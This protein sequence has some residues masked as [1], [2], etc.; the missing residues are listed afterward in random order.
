MVLPHT[1]PGFKG[2][3]ARFKRE[4][5]A[6]GA[7]SIR[8]PKTGELSPRST[9]VTAPP[10]GVGIGPGV[11]IKQAEKQMGR[12]FT[13]REIESIQRGST[14]IQQVSQQ[15]AQKRQ[16]EEQRKHVA[17]IETQRRVEE[18]M[19]YQQKS[20]IPSEASRWY[21]KGYMDIYGEKGVT[22]VHPSNVPLSPSELKE[23]KEPEGRYE[24]MMYRTKKYLETKEQ[25]AYKKPT[26]L[27]IRT[28]RRGYGTAASLVSSISTK[29]KVGRLA[30]TTGITA[31]A[32][33]ALS[34]VPGGQFIGAGLLAGGGAFYIPKLQRE[35]AESKFMGPVVYR[36]KITEKGSELAAATIGSAIGAKAVT[37]AKTPKIEGTLENVRFQQTKKTGIKIGKTTTGEGE[38]FT[39]VQS[40][41]DKLLGRGRIIKSRVKV[42]GVEVGKEGAKITR[43]LYYA[44][45]KPYQVMTYKGE[46]FKVGDITS[47]EIISEV[48]VKTGFGRTQ[49]ARFQRIKGYG[50]KPFE[51]L[52]YGKGKLGGS[53][54]ELVYQERG[55]KP[56]EYWPSDPIKGWFKAKPL[57]LGKQLTIK[58]KTIASPEKT[59]ETDWYRQL[60]ADL[61][62]RTLSKMFKS[63]KIFWFG[64]KKGAFSDIV[65]FEQPTIKSRKGTDFG[66]LK[67]KTKA[68]IKSVSYPSFRS[69]PSKTIVTRY[70]P[71]INLG[72]APPPS[73]IYAE[74]TTT[75]VSIKEEVKGISI[76]RKLSPTLG[77]EKTPITSMEMRPIQKP[78]QIPTQIPKQI[79]TQI[80][81]QIPTQIPRQLPKQVPRQV[82]KQVPRQLPKQLPKQIPKQIPLAIPKLY[83]KAI[84][85]EEILIPPIGLS[86]SLPKFKS[87]RSRQRFIKQETRYS[88]YTPTLWGQL[89]LRPI[90]AE[91]SLS[92]GKGG[93]KAGFAGC[94]Q[95]CPE[96]LKEGSDSQPLILTFAAGF[97]SRIC[98]KNQVSFINK[99]NRR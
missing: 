66:F 58:V 61:T 95:Q 1:Q 57:G 88:S 8:D 70:T 81:K 31:G 41:I 69:I 35:I 5:T 64:T 38:I 15:E 59:W 22:L 65:G 50:D 82:P 46:K 52:S 6:K 76:E 33:A 9:S 44:K 74:E 96:D 36:E 56:T 23:T 42:K 17:A 39:K 60:G 80:P 94:F 34:F 12:S 28:E 78:V 2:E 73:G 18:S 40:P 91:K 75:Q 25:A 97:L 72:F 19:A 90:K 98:Q 84:S 86:F 37:W 16:Q 11:S 48:G 77:L 89:F 85:I 45:V 43:S 55:V 10:L 79:P 26:S 20:H 54:V 47:S 3:T 99:I 53:R 30:L 4:K 14:T 67:T 87:P 63:E 51:I 21:Q 7:G 24:R 93:R 49:F 32:S 71:S 27:R 68:K 29:K 13:P 62:K 92:R 83:P